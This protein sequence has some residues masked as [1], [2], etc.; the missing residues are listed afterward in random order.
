MI[1][2]LIVDHARPPG[3]LR[4]GPRF[5]LYAV[6]GIVGVDGL[7]FT[8]LPHLVQSGA[9]AWAT[10]IMGPVWWGLTMLAT[11]ATASFAL[12]DDG[13]YP[14][15][16]VAARVALV[17]SGLIGGTFGLSIFV[18]TL[19]GTTSAITG[20][21]KWWVFFLIATRFLRYSDLFEHDPGDNGS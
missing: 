13:R 12:W 15:G 14:I 2:P 4:S 5:W 10:G 11:S 7:V 20:A 21:S 16:G 19:N 9:Y 1:D 3:R 6:A 8:L 18:L 17:L